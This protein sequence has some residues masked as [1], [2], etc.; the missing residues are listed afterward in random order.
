MCEKN[1][2]LSKRVEFMC[3]VMKIDLMVVKDAL[4]F[5]YIVE[6]SLCEERVSN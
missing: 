6:H 5:S 1:L 2:P 4:E 3:S